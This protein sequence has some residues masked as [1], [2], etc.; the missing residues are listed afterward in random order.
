MLKSVAGA[1]GQLN[2]TAPGKTRFRST[3]VEGSFE[4]KYD[5]NRWRSPNSY[6][7]FGWLRPNTST[8]DLLSGPGVAIRPLDADSTAHNILIVDNPKDLPKYILEEHIVTQD[9]TDYAVTG[10]AVRNF[11]ASG[12]YPIVPGQTYEFKFVISAAHGITVYLRRAGEE[13]YTQVLEAP[14]FRP[15][16]ELLFTNLEDY[17]RFGFIHYMED[18]VT[19][20]VN[21][22]TVQSIEENY[23]AFLYDF[24]FSAVLNAERYQ[25]IYVPGD[26]TDDYEIWFYYQDSDGTLG[27]HNVAKQS[28]NAVTIYSF[29]R[30]SITFADPTNPRLPVLVRTQS[31]SITTETGIVPAYLEAKYVAIKVLPTAKFLASRYDVYVNMFA[32]AVTKKY[33]LENPNSEAALV[34]A[35]E[36]IVLFVRSVNDVPYNTSWNILPNNPYDTFTLDNSFTLYLPESLQSEQSLT[37]EAIIIPRSI[38]EGLQ[39]LANQ[40]ALPGTQPR[41]RSFYPILVPGNTIEPIDALEAL[42]D[43]WVGNPDGWVADK[44]TGVAPAFYRYLKAPI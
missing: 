28:G 26:L 3:I 12:H 5:T 2:N 25:F 7:V 19:W 4:V 39:N 23:A 17:S 32:Q 24:D 14:A 11:I 35:P 9:A 27:W 42:T 16:N 40:Y 33:T 21:N 29:D 1:L 43:V 18:D 6:L 30:D 37:L 10:T 20:K 38:F 31:T 13:N 15:Y 34:W 44:K 36:D 8:A 22:L 41:I